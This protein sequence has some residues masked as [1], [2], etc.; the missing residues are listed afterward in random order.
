VND[1]AFRG[2]QKGSSEEVAKGTV[3]RRAAVMSLALAAAA[4]GPIAIGG[5][6][7]ATSTPAPTSPIITGLPS[8]NH[9]QFLSL[10]QKSSLNGHARWGIPNLDTLPNFSGQFHA[11]GVDANGNPQS[12]WL[13][14]FVG[15]PPE[16]GGTTNISAPVIPVSLQLLGPDGNP[17]IY[18]GNPL[19]SD[20]TQFVSPVLN[21]P[22]F[23][24]S[25]YSSSDTPTQFNDAIQRA[26]FYPQAQRHNWHTLL[27]GTATPGIVENVPYGAW[28][29]R[30]NPDGSCCRFVLIEYNTFN[31]IFGDAVNQAINNG[32]TTTKAISTFLFPN[33]YLF[34]G[35]TSNCCVLGY[36]TYFYNDLANGVEQRYVVNYSSWISP[37]LFGGGFQDVTAVSHEIAETFNDPFVVS[38]GVHGLTPWWLAPNGNCQ[39]NMETGDVIE[40]LPNAVYPITMNSYTY[41]PQNEALLQ[42]FEFQSSSDAIG[43]AYSYPDTSVLTGPSAPQ[44][45]YCQ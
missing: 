25:T 31:N 14:N 36:H 42:W 44:K 7:S 17:Y 15:N 1:H 3:R 39:D 34:F 29:A 12:K 10:N 2:L 9:P 21:S 43:G 11:S 22:V 6:A 41:H 16:H 35:S 30:L 27:N 28:A 40:G 38:D 8:G 20:A 24:N 32:W 26:E 37:G 13:T 4:I 33:T 45:L 18:M 19:Y 5:A 23:S